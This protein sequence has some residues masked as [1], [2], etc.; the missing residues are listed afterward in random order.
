MRRLLITLT[1]ALLPAPLFAGMEKYADSQLC[2]DIMPRYER[3]LGIPA[4]L[5]YSIAQNESGV[6]NRTAGKVTPWP[7][8]IGTSGRGMY[9]KTETEA[10][11][12]LRKLIASGVRNIDVGCMQVNYM[13]HPAAFANLDL[14][15]RPENNVGYAARFLRNNYDETRSW[16]AAVAYY[17]SRTSSFGTPYSNRVINSWIDNM[18]YTHL[19]KLPVAG[20]AISAPRIARQASG[21]K[22]FAANSK[23]SKK[24]SRDGAV[25]Q[26]VNSDSGSIKIVRMQPVRGGEAQF[27]DNSPQP[28]KSSIIRSPK[29]GTP[30]DFIFN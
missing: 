12:A 25:I 8:T 5:L 16:R 24:I 29:R 4:N 3:M 18:G 22:S 21:T 27:S 28:R 10:V 14:A 1:L 11:A 7:W 30:V 13:H 6:W 23:R 2:A 26:V 20:G 19:K 15:F 9:F 17:H